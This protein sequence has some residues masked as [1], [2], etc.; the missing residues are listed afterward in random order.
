MDSQFFKP[1]QRET[2]FN[3]VWYKHIYFGRTTIS[4]S[5]LD[6]SAQLLAKRLDGLPLALATAGTYIQRTGFTF[7]RYLQEYEARWNIDPHR[8]TKLQ[9]YRDRTLNTTWDLLYT[10]LTTEYPDAAKLLIV[11]AYFD[12]QKL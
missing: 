8:P 12:N 2:M 6:P 7:E 9:E 10:H 4:P 1:D 3:Q 5:L 11:L